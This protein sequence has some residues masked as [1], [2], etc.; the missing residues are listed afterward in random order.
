MIGHRLSSGPY[1]ASY[2][3]QVN[4]LHRFLLKV[5]EISGREVSLMNLRIERQGGHLV[6]W[7]K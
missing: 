7:I 2:E 1:P 3:T 4:D 6:V 5:P